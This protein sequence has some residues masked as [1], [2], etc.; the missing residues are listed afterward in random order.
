MLKIG[1]KMKISALKISLNDVETKSVNLLKRSVILDLETTRI[2]QNLFQVIISTFIKQ[3][4][5]GSSFDPYF[6][7]KYRILDF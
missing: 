1:T 4:G 6:Q 3:F 7:D 2:Y 5:C